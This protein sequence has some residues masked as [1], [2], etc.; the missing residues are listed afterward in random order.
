MFAKFDVIYFIATIVI[1]LCASSL[2]TQIRS[3]KWL[4][5]FMRIFNICIIYTKFVENIIQ[6]INVALQWPTAIEAGG[7]I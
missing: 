4:N 2:I 1:K 3:A 5:Y 6:Y 7:K